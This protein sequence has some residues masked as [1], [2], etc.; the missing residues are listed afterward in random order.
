MR[1]DIIQPTPLQPW[2]AGTSYG[3]KMERSLQFELVDKLTQICT[4]HRIDPD[5][6]DE[7]L[8]R[9]DGSRPDPG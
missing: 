2:L 3:R 1:R 6:L 8:A 4:R 9:F 5:K 7:V